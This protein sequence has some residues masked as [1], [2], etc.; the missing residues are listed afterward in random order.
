MR[1]D[2]NLPFLKIRA[3]LNSSNLSQTPNTTQVLRTNKAESKEMGLE[4]S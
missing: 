2:S 4:D 3:T 1:V